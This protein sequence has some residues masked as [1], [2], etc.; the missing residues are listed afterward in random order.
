MNNEHNRV[1]NPAIKHSKKGNI[2]F[3]Y[4]HLLKNMKKV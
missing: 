2:S 4:C 1:D 3:I